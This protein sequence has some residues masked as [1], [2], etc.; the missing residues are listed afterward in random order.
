[1]AYTETPMPYWK[2]MECDKMFESR[3]K[4]VRHMKDR[5]ERGVWL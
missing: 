4:H 5:H 1:M 3:E 2:C